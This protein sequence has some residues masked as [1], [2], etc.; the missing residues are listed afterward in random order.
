MMDFKKYYPIGALLA[1]VIV[2]FQ[3]IASV[4]GKEFFL[5][6]VTMSAYYSLVI[7]GLTVLMG[8]TGQISI[9]HAAFFAMGGYTTAVLTTTNLAAMKQF[10]H[11]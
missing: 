5:V 6:Q 9:G 3:V 1:A 8:Y 7:I 11:I 2:M 4:A 10:I